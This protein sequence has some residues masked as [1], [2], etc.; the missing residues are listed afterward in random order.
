MA[1]RGN[2]HPKEQAA[3]WEPRRQS[4]YARTQLKNRRSQRRKHRDWERLGV[5]GQTRSTEW[6]AML[7]PT[8]S[9]LQACCYS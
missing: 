6:H 1:K 7:R 5:A 4:Y 2:R 8:S 3:E 9:W